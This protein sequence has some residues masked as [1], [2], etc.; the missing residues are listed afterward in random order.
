[1]KKPKYIKIQKTGPDALNMFEKEIKAGVDNSCFNKDILSD[2]NINYAK[3]EKIIIDAKNKCFPVKEVK[4]NKYKH[5]ITQWV[6]NGIIQSIK[7]ETKCMS[8]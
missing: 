7:K 3:L 1:M 5:R 8:I 6:T 2:P 4:F